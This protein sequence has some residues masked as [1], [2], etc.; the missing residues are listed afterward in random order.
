MSLTDWGF[1]QGVKDVVNFFRF[2]KEMKREMEDPSSMFNRYGLKLNWLRNIVYV[3]FNCKEEDLQKYDYNQERMV[4][5]KIKP[6][7]DYMTDLGWSEYLVPEFNNFTD[8]D[9]KMTLSY[10]VLLVFTPVRFSGRWIRRTALWIAVITAAIILGVKFIPDI[11][12]RL[13]IM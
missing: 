8:E 9:G 4:D 13:N 11:C 1:V 5:F 6:I 7:C 10:G 2:R 12:A 3:Q